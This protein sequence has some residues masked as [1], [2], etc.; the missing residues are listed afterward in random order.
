MNTIVVGLGNPILCD[1]GI[2]VQAVKILGNLLIQPEVIIAE[3]NLSGLELIELIS[4][5]KKAILI[6]AIQTKNGSVGQIYRFDSNIFDN[7]RHFSSPHDMNFSTALSFAKQMGVDIPNEIILFAVEV[8]DLVTF[9]ETCTQKV[10]D[11]IPLL[12]EMVKKE[13]Y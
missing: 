10:L 8:E 13:L 1:D 11:A 3:S 12:L 6:D 7:L 9:S 5:Y 2:G 4:G